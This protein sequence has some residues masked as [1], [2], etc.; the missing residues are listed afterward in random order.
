M[1][2]WCDNGLT[3]GKFTQGLVYTILTS[4]LPIASA[5]RVQGNQIGRQRQTAFDVWHKQTKFDWIL[6][7]DSD[8]VITNDAVNLSPTVFIISPLCVFENYNRTLLFMLLLY[9]YLRYKSMVFH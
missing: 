3:D 6:W 2:T 7:I 1:V 8:I 4:D 9:I 5:Q